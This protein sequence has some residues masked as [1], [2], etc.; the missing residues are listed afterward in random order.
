[1]QRKR[2]VYVSEKQAH[3][4]IVQTVGTMDRDQLP[5]LGPGHLDHSHFSTWENLPFSLPAS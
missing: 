2:A 5:C 1:M 4:N 3:A